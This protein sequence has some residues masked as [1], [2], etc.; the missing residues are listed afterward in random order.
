MGFSRLF[1]SL[2]GFVCVLFLNQGRKEKAAILNYD[3]ITSGILT[4]SEDDTNNDGSSNVLRLRS[5]APWCQEK[6]ERQLT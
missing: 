1:P 4:Q 6:L 2:K 5:S 3:F